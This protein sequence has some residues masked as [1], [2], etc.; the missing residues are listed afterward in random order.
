MEAA[1][2]L[3][4]TKRLYCSTDVKSSNIWYLQRPSAH[5]FLI[6]KN[7]YNIKRRVKIQ[8][9]RPHKDW[10]QSGKNVEVESLFISIAQ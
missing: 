2:W 9:N 7:F 4:L 3:L 10:E 1:S 6:F 5:S 8:N